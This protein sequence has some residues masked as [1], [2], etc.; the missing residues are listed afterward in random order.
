MTRRRQIG[1]D[2]SWTGRAQ[3]KSAPRAI[4]PL[5]SMGERMLAQHPLLGVSV[6]GLKEPGL[7]IIAMAR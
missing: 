3:Q 5:G 7:G 1:W 4:M 2:D 6:L